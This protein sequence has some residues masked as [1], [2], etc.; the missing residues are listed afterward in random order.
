MLSCPLTENELELN[1]L[2]HK[3]LLPQISFATVAQDIQINHVQSLV[4]LE[5]NFPSQKDACHQNLADFGNDN[6]SIRANDKGEK[7][8][9]KPLV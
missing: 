3:Q 1:H 4:N 9:L 5:T 2:K 6:F 8:L 7:I